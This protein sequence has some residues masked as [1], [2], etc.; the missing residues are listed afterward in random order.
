[1]LKRLGGPSGLPFFA[2]LDT[3]GATIVNSMRPVGGGKNPQ[4]IGH[5]DTPEEIDWFMVMLHKAVPQM[6]TAESATLERRLRV[7]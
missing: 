4:N 7:R 3:N 5:P 1:M 2:F 6:T